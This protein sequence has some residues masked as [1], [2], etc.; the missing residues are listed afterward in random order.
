MTKK[1]YDGIIEA[2]RFTRNGQID[3]VRA[4]ERR[5]DTYSDRLLLDR[6]TL[7][8]RLKMK[9]RFII[10]QRMEFLASTFNNDREVHLIGQEGSQYVSTQAESSHDELEGAPLF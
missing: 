8:E 3:M 5:G 7:I 9:K 10:G 2:V 4:Y 6:K 1:N